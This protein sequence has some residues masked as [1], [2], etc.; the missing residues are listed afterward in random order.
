MYRFLKLKEVNFEYQYSFKNEFRN[1]N[2]QSFDFFFPELKI[3][4]EIDGIQHYDDR[5]HRGNIDRQ[6]QNKRDR[7]KNRYCLKHGI[8]IIRIFPYIFDTNLLSVFLRAN[9]IIK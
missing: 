3:A 9:K 4:L 8:K 6:E 1:N 7:D 2:Y 5:Y